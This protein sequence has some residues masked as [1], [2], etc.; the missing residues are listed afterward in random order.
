MD[1]LQ[2]M[3]ERA[4][5][6]IDK[7]EKSLDAAHDGI[8]ELKEVIVGNKEFKRPGLIDRI[9]AIENT[10]KTD[11]FLCRQ[12]ISALDDEVRKLK[13]KSVKQAAIAGGI[14]LGVGL[15]GAFLAKVLGFFKLLMNIK[16]P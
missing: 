10:A 8:R 1:I 6:A 5:N 13:D 16:I 4:E 14:G 12:R 3:R 9:D 7:I 2:K 15:V 11:F